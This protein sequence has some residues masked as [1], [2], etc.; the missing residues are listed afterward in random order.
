M[1][2][3]VFVIVV[4]ETRGKERKETHRQQPLALGDD[5]AK[6]LVRVRNAHNSLSS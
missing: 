3:L 4:G 6:V 1:P 5:E 2:A